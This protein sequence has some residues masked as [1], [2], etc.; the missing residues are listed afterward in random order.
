M[1][2]RYSAIGLVTGMIMIAVGCEHIHDPWVSEGEQVED[3][4]MRSAELDK[5][6]D[7]RALNQAGR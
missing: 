6:L 2:V 4:R 7:E 3:G 5:A 1:I